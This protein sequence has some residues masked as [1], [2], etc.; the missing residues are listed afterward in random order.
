MA[1]PW[2]ISMVVH[3]VL[4]MVLAMIRLGQVIHPML[5]IEASYSDKL[6]E[7]ML[8]DSVVTTALETVENVESALS[9]DVN[10]VDN[11]LA[12]MPKLDIA[13]QTPG[14]TINL[15]APSIGMALTGREKGAKEALLSAYGGNATTEGAVTMALEW[16]RKQQQKDGTWS[17]TGPFA[18]GVTVDNKAAATAMA[19]LAFQGNGETHLKG[20]H[21]DAVSRGLKALLK[22]QDK[23]GN[24][25]HEGISG[26]RLYAQAMASIV[27]CELYG[28]TKDPEVKQAAERALNYAAK[29]QAD[30]GQGGGGWRYHPGQ[31]VDTSVTG[32]FVMAYQSGRMAG[33]DSHSQTLQRVSDYLDHVEKV[34]TEFNA[35]KDISYFYRVGEDPRLS[36]TAEALLCRQ[37]LGWDRN[38]PRLVA[39]VKKLLLPEN[40]IHWEDPNFYYWYYATQVM[41][42]M[43]GNEWHEWNQVMREVLPR[44]QE[45]TGKEKGSW[46]PAGD[47]FG[48]QGG[49]L[50]ST[51]F[52]V[53]MLESYYRHL[54]IYRH[55]S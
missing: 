36:M 8:D 9:K 35:I 41:H 23:D 22:M 50:Y 34:E 16:L 43:G 32:W 20:A 14:A 11:P 39:G 26:H 4:L 28:M 7:Q 10:P 33:L 21:R 54:P 51:C 12:A 13:L 24:F 45:K 19:L 52:C 18:N 3:L 53:F 15:E 37:Y 25:V 5:V 6:G 38:E 2:L 30:D 46:S 29:I 31:D 1:P 42:H 27:V 44:A 17:L 49:R 47:E 48:Y 40:R 55:G